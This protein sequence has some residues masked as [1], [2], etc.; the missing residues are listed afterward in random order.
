[1]FKAVIFDIDGTLL[2]SVDAHAESWVRTFAHFGVAADFAKVR[3]HIG[4]GG[5]RL[6]PAFMGN[7]QPGGRGA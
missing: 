1:V 3:S 7:L 5:D 6:M 4:E 2:D